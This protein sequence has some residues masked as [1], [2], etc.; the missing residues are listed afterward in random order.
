MDPM[1]LDDSL[2]LFSRPN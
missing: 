1:G 2:L